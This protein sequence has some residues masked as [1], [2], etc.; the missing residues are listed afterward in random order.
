MGGGWGLEFIP[1]A[2]WGLEFIPDAR[3]P[4]DTGSRAPRAARAAS[5]PTFVVVFTL[6]AP[7]QSSAHSG[8]AL[9]QSSP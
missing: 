4:P 3:A 7:N 1:D 6:A 8:D 2:R 9:A 5:A